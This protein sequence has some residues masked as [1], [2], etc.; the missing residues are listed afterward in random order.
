[1]VLCN[2]GG[3]SP[4][5]NRAFSAGM[6]NVFIFRQLPV[7]GVMQMN[8]LKAVAGFTNRFSQPG[9]VNAHCDIPCGIYDPHGAQVAAHSVIRMT[10]LIQE[11]KDDHHALA[12]YVKVKE[13]HAELCK[14]EIRIIWGDY[15]KPEH[16]EK[17][18]E[19]HELAWKIMKQAS[20]ARQNIDLK[21]AEELLESV[22]RFAEIFWETKGISTRRAKAP[23]PTER[24]MVYPEV[25]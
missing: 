13:E 9:A 17:H 21:A 14:H 12:R 18:P 3:K 8:F 24:E 23:Y 4:P 7:T 15:V 11:N 22:N 5:E 1:M 25:K 6:E 19:I 10:Q 16:A 2:I 20:A